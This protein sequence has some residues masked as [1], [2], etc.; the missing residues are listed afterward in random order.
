MPALLDA[1]VASWLADAQTEYPDG[2]PRGHGCIGHEDL[3]RVVVEAL[4]VLILPGLS[5]V[6]VDAMPATSWVQRAGFGR[7]PANNSG[8]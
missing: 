8:P 2:L 3:A 4:H 1:C 5:H 7:G 6:R